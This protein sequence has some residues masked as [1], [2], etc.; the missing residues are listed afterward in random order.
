[1]CEECAVG[2]VGEYPGQQL[3]VTALPE[4][5]VGDGGI[6]QA[7]V[8]NTVGYVISCFFVQHAFKII[9]KGQLIVLLASTL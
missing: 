3:N 2:T 6:F 1:M 7:E 4:N 8:V 9:G 5:R